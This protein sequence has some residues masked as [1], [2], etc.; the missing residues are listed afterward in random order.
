MV[1]RSFNFL[2]LID[3]YN[4]PHRH[5]HN[6]SHIAM[7]Y[8]WAR[9]YKIK[10]SEEQRLAILFHDVHYSVDKKKNTFMGK[11][12]SN[13]ELSADIAQEWCKYCFEEDFVK[14]VYQIIR[15]TEIHIPTIPESNDVLDLDL[16]GLSFSCIYKD[17]GDK[18][19]QEYK[20]FSN[21]EFNKGRSDWIE[22]MLKRESIYTGFFA[23]GDYEKNARINLEKN[24]KEL[25][26]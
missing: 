20:H 26:P 14:R 4:E 11:Y 6:F 1:D 17:V 7:M 16:L 23:S 24:F 18:I 8:D 21:K 15:D 13:E 25:N 12:V 10:L 2:S 9:E 3:C 19:R 5:Y 22:S